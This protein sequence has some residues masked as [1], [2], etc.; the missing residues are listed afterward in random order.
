MKAEDY[1]FQ[2]YKSK[3]GGSLKGQEAPSDEL[4]KQSTLGQ[5]C[6]KKYYDPVVETMRKKQRL[7]ANL[8]L[9]YMSLISNTD[10]YSD[11]LERGAT[12]KEAAWVALGRAAGIYGVDRYLHLGA[13]FY[14]DLTAESI[15]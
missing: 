12:K 11:M 15:T 13:V 4:W 8:A 3:V 6:M 5:L 14:D 7:G 9:A 1:A 2:I 10:V